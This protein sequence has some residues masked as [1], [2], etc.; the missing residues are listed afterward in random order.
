MRRGFL[1]AKEEYWG[2]WQIICALFRIWLSDWT[3]LGFFMRI[4]DTG[5][6][7]PP[8]SLLLSSFG[9]ELYIEKSGNTWR[10]VTDVREWDDCLSITA[11]F[12][13]PFLRCLTYTRSISPACFVVESRDT[14]LF[15]FVLGPWRAGQSLHWQ[16]T[17]LQN[18]SSNLC[19]GYSS[20]HS[21]YSDLLFQAVQL[22]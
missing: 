12:I 8:K 22:V 17:L 15:W 13:H 19:K 3:Q 2:K 5:I 16:T 14:D 4:S 11:A 6:L 1:S 18:W 9:G 20:L 21:A 10:A 7:Q